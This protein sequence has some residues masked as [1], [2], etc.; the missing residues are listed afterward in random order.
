MVRFDQIVFKLADYLLEGFRFLDILRVEN[1]INI[2]IKEA[3]AY[4]VVISRVWD[5]DIDEIKAATEVL[6]D[7]MSISV[8]AVHIAV[9]T[10]I[11][12]AVRILLSDFF[13][14]KLELSDLI[15]KLYLLT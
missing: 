15:Y 4:K 10:Q 7:D 5:R 8:L 11:N 6:K 3:L 2:A 13:N 14:N 1:H 9:T 12:I